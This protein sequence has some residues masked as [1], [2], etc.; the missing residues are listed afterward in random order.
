MNL[1]YVSNSRFPSEKAQS[2]QIMQMCQALAALGHTVTLCVPNRKGI[3]GEDPFAYYRRIKTFEVVRVPCLDWTR[4]S[5]LG[6]LGFWVQTLSFIVSLRSRLKQIPCNMIYS[7]ELYVLAVKKM[8]MRRVWEAHSLHHSFFAR[9]L[10]RSLDAVVT[11]THASR[12]RLMSF[13]V[14]QKRIIVEPDAVDPELFLQAPTRTDARARLGIPEKAFL[15]LYVGKFTTMGMPKGVDES[16]DAVQALQQEGCSLYFMGV[17]ATQD[18]LKQYAKRESPTV[19]L[20][21]HRPQQELKQFYAAAD[22]VLM[23]FPWTEHYAFFMSLLK[24]FEYL[25][26][27]VPIIAS[28]LP[29]V[30][31]I[32]QESE[33]WLITPGSVSGL[34][35][36]IK[37]VMDHPALA[38]DKAQKSRA[39]ANRYTWQARA[40]RIMEQLSV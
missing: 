9:A 35:D 14:Q 40:Q 13:G 16:I 37:A 19:I 25:M 36:A 20:M 33:A 10:T 8:G 34:K 30:R 15:C 27:G 1:V 31:E 32:I 6:R 7:R 4:F 28:D 5:W 12:E 3:V 21:G 39:L 18:E 24:L 2:D 11:L 22:V 38:K 26:S 29:S 23:P 17:G